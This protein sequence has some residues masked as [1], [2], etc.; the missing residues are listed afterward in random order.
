MG[1]HLAKTTRLLPG[2]Q[3]ASENDNFVLAGANCDEAHISTQRYSQKLTSEIACIEGKSFDLQL[4]RAS[5]NFTV[6]LIP[7]D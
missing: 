2:L 1:H 6:Y 3:I 4:S 7:S 5:V